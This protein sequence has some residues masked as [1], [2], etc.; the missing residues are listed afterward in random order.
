M[1]ALVLAGGSGTRLRP[2]S[3]SMPKQLIPIANKPVLVHCLESLAAIG[4]RDV[5]LIVGDRIAEIQAAVGDGAELGLRITYIQQ[6]RPRGL[7]HCV[8]IARA[9]LGDDDFVMYLGDNMLV[10]GIQMLADE[11]HRIRP[12]VQVAVTKVEDP[13]EYGVVEVAAD[14]RVTALVEKPEQPRTDLALIG[15]YFFTPEIHSAVRRIVP[16]ARG[17]LEITEAIALLVDEGRPV[18]AGR[19]E[20]YW[21]DTGRVD[22]VLDCNREL[23][24]GVTRQID[25]LV[26]S[27][28]E[29]I[30]DV[31]VESGATVLRSRV[32]GPVMIA[33]GSRIEDSTIGP[34]TTIGRDCVLR[35]A[36]VSQSIVLDAVAVDQVRGIYGSIIG[37]GARVHSVPRDTRQRL[38]LG[39]HT[40][41]EI[42][43]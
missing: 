26:D 35:G 23:L 32:V 29:L 4:I 16:S 2:F 21:K 20:G 17:E 37:R 5:G 43:A 31:V 40:E 14:G 38:V 33:A 7:A 10:G 1:K 42:A 36:G 41:V 3:Y 24:G 12:A 22:D 13:R 28:S 8:R 18:Y 15:V 11:F 27:A 9:F 30:G 39:D 6:D 34:Y 25:G 19:F